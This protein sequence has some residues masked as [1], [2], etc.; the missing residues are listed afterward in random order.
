M[1]CRGRPWAVPS[2]I[3]R[4]ALELYAAQK[5]RETWPKL[6]LPVMPTMYHVRDVPT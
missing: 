6:L 5:G 4:F 3:I 2:G 1:I